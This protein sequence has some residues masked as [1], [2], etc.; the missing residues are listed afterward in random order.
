MYQ[1]SGKN[2]DMTRRPGGQTGP[3]PELHS[4]YETKFGRMFECSVEDFLKSR[5][6]RRL[7]SKVQLVFTSPPFPL[8]RKKAYGNLE[9]DEFKKWLS[10]LAPKL[11]EL[12]TPDGSIVM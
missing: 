6:A 3:L 1:Y 11:S 10:D 8:N 9:G 5:N 12:L 7:Q 4:A 2:G